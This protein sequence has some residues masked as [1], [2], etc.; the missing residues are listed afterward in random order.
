MLVRLDLAL[1]TRST[2]GS[3]LRLL[4]EAVGHNEL[5]D[6]FTLGNSQCVALVTDLQ[7]QVHKIDAFERLYAGYNLPHNDTKTPNI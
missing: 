3:V 6:R 4:L 2:Y 1:L 5:E 7:R